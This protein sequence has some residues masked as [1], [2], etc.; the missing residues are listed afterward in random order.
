[1]LPGAILIIG[2]P[3]IDYIQPY[4]WTIVGL[5][6]SAALLFSAWRMKSSDE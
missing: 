5:A 3:A 4:P 6:T 1:M 2:A